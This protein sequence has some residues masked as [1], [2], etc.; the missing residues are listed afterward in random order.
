ML[1]AWAASP[2]R[3]REDA[4][5]E[6][7]LALGGYR[8]RL[9]V[10]L[11]QNAADAAARAGVPGRLRLTLD[12]S[13]TGGSTTGT[14]LRAANVG[15]P[16]DL[17]GVESLASL[18]ASA[19]RDHSTVGRF[20][21][22]FVAVLAVT[23]DPVLTSRA[24]GVRFS[25]AAA[26]AAVEAQP[27]LAAEV[28]HRAGHVPVLRLPWPDDGAPPAGFD[29]EVRLPLRAGEVDAVRAM[30]AAVDP[31]LL[32]S[33]PG[34][35]EM[36]IGDR[37]LRR[38]DHDGGADLS[39][40]GRVTRWRVHRDTGRIPADLLAERPTEERA[41]PDW[42]LCWAVPVDGAD[43]PL[44]PPGD[45][46]LHAPTPSEEPVSLPARLIGTFPLGPDRRHVE[47]GPLT[48]HLIARAAAGYA[49]LAAG[50]AARPEILTL[51]PRPRLAGSELDTA[52][53][54]AALDALR[55]AAV[56]ATV[57][58]TRV[59]APAAVVVDAATPAL[60]DALADTLEGLL[61]AEWSGRS[62][63]PALTALGVRRLS[64]A[65]LVDLLAGV[66]RPAS[67]W[68]RVYAGLA[69]SPDREALTGLPVPLADGRT[70]TGPREV[71][72]PDSG[73]P[74]QALGPL[75]L[76]VVDPDAA[77]P[78]LERL[79][80]RPA[81]ARAVLADDRVRAAVE[82]S[83]DEDDP[84]PVAEAVLALV[85]A[86]GIVPGELP[87][88]AEL[89]L[90]GDDG[91][92]YPAGEV[93]LPDSPLADIV[94]ADAPFGRLDPAYAGRWGTEALAA[95]GAL[96]TFAVLRAEDID[97]TDAD[98]D[99][100]DEQAWY[101]AVLDRLPD[102]DVPP[103]LTGPVAVRDLELVRPD[104][105]PAALVLLATEPLRT[106]VL[107]P[108]VAVLPDGA[109][110]EVTSYT[111]WW[112]A[113]HPVLDGRRPD[114][115]RVRAATDLA[116][117]YDEADVDTGLAALLGV[118]SGID[119]VLA[120]ADGA[121]DLLARLA[122]SG[123]TAPAAVLPDLYPRIARSLAGLAVDRPAGVRV[124]PDRVVE[125]SRVVV[126]DAPYLLPVLDASVVPGGDDPEEVAD[127]LGV[128]LASQRR[129]SAGVT[130]TSTETVRWA[131]VPGAELAARRCGGSVPA[132]RVARHEGL[133]VAG[134]AVPWWP[135]G[136]VDHIDAGAGPQALGRAVAW[137]LGRWDRRAA[138]A[139]AL[140]RPG[141]AAR[142]VAE[143]AAE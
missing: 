99:L 86:A 78:L 28:G 57:G 130:S 60:V 12:R 85:T 116:G 84:D 24:G 122:D 16:L 59:A 124:D 90:P 132:G 44:P 58:G 18:R 68:R 29:T 70:V 66:D 83:Y 88:L 112:L 93:L 110:V 120:D 11:A 30:L 6:E 47:P 106:A 36:Q 109:R 42:S 96:G 121:R 98:H 74:A 135:D 10:E 137:R 77:H 48:D 49:A 79:G 73:L 20:G 37:L 114:R 94:D 100:D 53:C 35:A 34:L 108:A 65:D 89:A 76:R 133:R 15:A 45:P 134:V 113:T 1:E 17:A 54:R 38:A 128:D 25:A 140:D 22:G 13:A 111:R 41:R 141:D 123:R 126:L 101:D 50:L 139:E 32:L 71:L 118:R 14:V 125:R 80:A 95:V 103:L 115:M 138:A 39:D 87:W 75:G 142:L 56:L 51:V 26:R 46:V 97:P 107:T 55:S 64:T 127:L 63:A 129:P 43:L 5:A 8:D 102:T 105:W 3:F 119:D 82:A 136:D 21:V 131:D 27:S 31:E 40:D 62:R 91:Q 33:L 104:R 72:L 117:L 143:D 69:D 2:A 92:H 7:D 4:N 9:V 23:D 19:K 67:W 81:T 52:L 61:G